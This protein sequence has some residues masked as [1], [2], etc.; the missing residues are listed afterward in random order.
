MVI[1][2]HPHSLSP[3]WRPDARGVLTSP[4]GATI[5][6]FPTAALAFAFDFIYK[7]PVP[8]LSCLSHG[9]SVE[10]LLLLF[11]VYFY[12]DFAELCRT[13][14]W[15]REH[16]RFVIPCAPFGLGCAQAWL[17]PWTSPLISLAVAL[18]SVPSM[19]VSEVPGAEVFALGRGSVRHA[20]MSRKETH[21]GGKRTLVTM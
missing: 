13:S 5:A 10:L 17:M 1:K 6:P 7:D 11:F 20:E 2:L 4:A 9:Q 16:C 8:R 3:R 15:W 12:L 14:V 18:L 21:H 19:S